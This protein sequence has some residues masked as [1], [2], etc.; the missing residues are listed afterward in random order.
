MRIQNP[1]LRKTAGKNPR[2]YIRP[3]VDRLQSDNSIKRVKERVYLGACAETSRRQAL[4]EAS[5]AMATLNE[6]KRVVMAQVNFGQF[7]DQYTKN[8]VLKPDHL[9]S[10]TQ[11]KYTNHINNHIRPA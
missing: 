6:R 4:A 3:Y 5:R 7:L 11:D 9:A 8:Y 2:W 1:T 10:S